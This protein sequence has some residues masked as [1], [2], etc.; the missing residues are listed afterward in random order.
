MGVTIHFEGA[1]KDEVAFDQLL[2]SVQAFAQSRTWLTERMEPDVKKLM[3]LLRE[4]EEDWDYV[5]PVKGL[6]LY[7]HDDCDPVRL[8]FDENLYV[9]EFVKTQFAGTAIHVTVIEFLRSIEC[10]FERL[11]VNDEG[12]YWDAANLEELSGHIESCR[13][14]IERELQKDP[15]ARIK[16]RTPEGRIMDLVR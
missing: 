7:V 1:L 16:V 6:I 3:R 12:E 9:Q 8:E 5:G 13:M 4:T 10:F 2:T 15:E 11:Y 14:A